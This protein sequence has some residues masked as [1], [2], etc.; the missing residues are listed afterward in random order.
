M[1][2]KQMAEK[3]HV[4]LFNHLSWYYMCVWFV[5]LLCMNLWYPK[6]LK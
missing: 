2:V 4:L 1:A 6:L 3:E 5:T